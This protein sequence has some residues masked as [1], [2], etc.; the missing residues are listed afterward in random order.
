MNKH[1]IFR[2]NL[3]DDIKDEVTHQLV[4]MLNSDN[5]DERAFAITTLLEYRRVLSYWPDT[6][7]H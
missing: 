2:G 6:E 3:S 1:Y 5:A 4:T 7:S